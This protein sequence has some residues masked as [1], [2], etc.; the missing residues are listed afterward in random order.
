MWRITPREGVKFHD[1]APFNADA[2][3]KPI[4]RLKNEALTCRDR[5]KIKGIALTTAVVDDHTI[6]ITADPGQVL[7]PTMLSF[8]AVASP[9]RPNDAMSRAPIGTGPMKFVKWDTAG[10]SVAPYAEYCGRNR[11]G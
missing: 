8:I 4:G 2:V 10:I 1:G 7:M 6:D 5:T 3:A 11:R 9:N